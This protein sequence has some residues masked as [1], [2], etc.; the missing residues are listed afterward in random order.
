MTNLTEKVFGVVNVCDG[1]ELVD[2]VLSPNFHRLVKVPE[3]NVVLF[4][5]TNLLSLRHSDVS[6][7]V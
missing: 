1:A 4:V 3:V 7:V 5:N 6:G 2:V